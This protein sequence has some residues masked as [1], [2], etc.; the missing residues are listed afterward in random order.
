MAEGRTVGSK[1][2]R[3]YVDGYDLSGYARS[4]GELQWAYN[5]E[6]FN[7]LDAEV[8]GAMPGQCTIAVGDINS[9][10]ATSTGT[11]TPQDVFKDASDA[12]HDV[13]IPLGIRAAPASGDPAFCAQV[14]QNA[15]KVDVDG[16]TITSLMDL[17][18]QDARAGSTGAYDIPWGFVIHA[19]G[20]ET[21]PNSGTADHTFGSQTLKGGYMMYQV[22]GAST[23]TVTLKIEDS[24]GG[25]FSALASSGELTQT[26]TGQ[27][28]IIALGPTVTVDTELRFQVDFNS[29]DTTTFALAFV[30]GR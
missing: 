19:K 12:V 22:F 14:S 16:D 21:T 27:S 4:V 1:F 28:G 5:P 8:V 10:M 17:G 24:T 20:A 26:S 30:R 15:Y 13:M 25:S 11:V 29:A 9:V 6:E 3:A 7:A 2:T 23:G 18:S